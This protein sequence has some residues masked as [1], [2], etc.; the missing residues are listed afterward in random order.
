MAENRLLLLAVI[1]SLK[2]SLASTYV[3]DIMTI[4]WKLIEEEVAKDF[5]FGIHCISDLCKDVL[6]DGGYICLVVRLGDM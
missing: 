4:N 5:H 3:K 6:Y 1:A 2:R